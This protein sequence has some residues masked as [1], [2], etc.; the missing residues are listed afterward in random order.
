[1]VTLGKIR[2]ND[3]STNIRV[4]IQDTNSLDVN[5]LVDVSA[6]ITLQIT[7]LDPDGN[8]IVDHV[9]GLTKPN[10]GSD[11]LVQYVT[12]GVT[13][14]WTKSGFWSWWIT[15]D[16]GGGKKNTFSAIREVLEDGMS[17]P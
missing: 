17:Q 16:I 12:S 1:M 5:V 10:G 2:V 9:S 13:S 8:V 4:L 11:G 15:Y 6:A 14:I 3:L 7:I